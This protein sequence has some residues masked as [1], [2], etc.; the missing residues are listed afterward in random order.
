MR[1]TTS[2]TTSACRVVFLD[3]G[4][5]PCGLPFEQHLDASLLVHLAY[6]AHER[7]APAEVAARIAQA[8]VVVT[9]KVRLGAE[10]LAQ[11]PQLQRIC[12]AAAGMDN[13]D[14]QAA[15]SL[16]ITVHNV[17]D[18]GS[19]SV[20]EHVMATLLALRRHLAEYSRAAGDGRWS[21][22]PHFCWHGPRIQPVGGSTLG[23]V[24]RGRIGQA[25]ARLAQGLGMRVLFAQRP[26]REAAGDERPL[27]DLL[28]QCD[29]VSLHVPLTP[30]TRGLIDA[31]RLALMKPDAVLINTGR[32]ALVD[33]HALVAALQ[34]QRLAGAAID[35]LEVEPPPPD[36]PL[37]APGIPNL[38]L[39]PHVAW[40][41][42]QAQ[43]RLA[44][45]LAEQVA[46]HLRER[47]LRA[48]ASPPG[49]A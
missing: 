33:P 48:P 46:Q 14:L 17:P 22:S 6:Q 13:V 47:A 39:T 21:A 34:A 35:V 12:I 16:G 38:L 5:L 43:Q 49:A 9:N 30:D 3:A 10:L 11:A 41:S 19:D 25:T 36:H 32:G 24:G 40:A 31:R 45:R 7:T 26:G 42:E 8:E 15:R 44:S 4:T 23:I 37:L 20:A 1:S 29:A 27:D 28:A 2:T 18:Y